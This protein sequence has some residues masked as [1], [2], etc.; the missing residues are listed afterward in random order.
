MA[1]QSEHECNAKISRTRW[2]GWLET[3]RNVGVGLSLNIFINSSNAGFR[4]AMGI[5]LQ[6]DLSLCSLGQVK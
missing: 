1:D 5:K 3:A 4:R 2:S 6:I